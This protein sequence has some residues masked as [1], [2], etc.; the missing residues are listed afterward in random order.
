[1][2][3]EEEIFKKIIDVCMEFERPAAVRVHDIELLCEVLKPSF[4]GV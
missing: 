2:K 1:M 3:T 4:P